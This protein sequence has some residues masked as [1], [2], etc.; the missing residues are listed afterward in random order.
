MTSYL[1]PVCRSF[2]KSSSIEIVVHFVRKVTNL[3]GASVTAGENSV[4]AG[5]VGQL[6]EL[7]SSSETVYPVFNMAGRAA[8]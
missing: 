3:I 7:L 6:A 5:L 8:R 1:I 2:R 4:V